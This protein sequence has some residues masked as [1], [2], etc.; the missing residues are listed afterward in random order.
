MQVVG[1]RLT[2]LYYVDLLIR[3]TSVPSDI[4][5]HDEYES[6]LQYFFEVRMRERIMKET[7][8]G[9]SEKSESGKKERAKLGSCNSDPH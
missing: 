9:L 2:H 6:C 4:V 7:L 1:F 3:I 8:K 5:E